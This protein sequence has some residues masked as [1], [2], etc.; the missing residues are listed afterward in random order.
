MYSILTFPSLLFYEPPHA[1]SFHGSRLASDGDLIDGFAVLL[2]LLKNGQHTPV[3]RASGRQDQR[4][5]HNCLPGQAG[6][7]LGRRNKVVV[8]GAVPSLKGFFTTA[9]NLDLR[10]ATLNHNKVR[11]LKAGEADIPFPFHLTAGGVPNLRVAVRLLCGKGI[12][13]NQEASLLGIKTS[14]L[15]RASGTTQAVCVVLPTSRLT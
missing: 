3:H 5:K 6:L 12:S 15:C 8:S 11:I 1:A 9:E 14:R 2:F 13:Y 10:V 7:D 4:F